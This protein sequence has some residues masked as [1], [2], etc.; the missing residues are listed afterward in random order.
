MIN[1]RTAISLTVAAVLMLSLSCSKYQ[2][3]PFISFTKKNKRIAGTWKHSAFVYLDQNVTVTDNLP[4]TLYTYTED[5][6]Y[7]TSAGDTG[8]WEFGEGVDL[9]I[10]LKGSDSVIT[11]EILR[12]AKKDLWLKT[13]QQEWHF[14]H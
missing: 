1:M 4:A 9:N 2:D 7:Y 11:F 5:N 10:R 3:G 12:L 14:T 6:Q 8:T 13:G